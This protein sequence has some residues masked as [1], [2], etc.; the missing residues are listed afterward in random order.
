VVEAVEHR[1]KAFVERFGREPAPDEPLFFDMACDFPVEADW[2]QMLRQLAATAH[3]VGVNPKVLA[4]YLITEIG[5]RRS[6]VSA[7]L[8]H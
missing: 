2:A 8:V 4:D 1:L 3:A 5:S 6:L 7:R